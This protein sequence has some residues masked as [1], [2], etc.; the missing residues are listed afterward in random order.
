MSE[1]KTYFVLFILS[2]S[3]LIALGRILQ[4]QV[5]EREEFQKRIEKQYYQEEEIILPRGTIFDRNGKFAAI[6][7]PT[8]SVYVIPKY[9]KDKENTAKQLSLLLKIPYE[10]LRKVLYE[11]KNYTII[12]TNVDKSLRP[13]LEKLRFDLKEWNIGILDNSMRFYPFGFTA[14]NVIGFVSKKT[15]LGLEGMEYQ[16]NDY[17]GGGKA[18][19]RFLK[20]AKG[21]LIAIE[22]ADIQKKNYNAVLT[23]D[24]NVQHI[25]EDSLMELV[26]ER[27]P[28]EAAVLIMNPYTGEILAA[29]SYPNYDPNNYQAYKYR[30]NI[31]FQHAYEVGSV[32]KPIILAEAIDEKK[33]NLNEIIDC[34]NGSIYVDGIRI[35]DHKKFGLLTPVQIIQHSSNVGAIKIALRLDPKSVYKKLRDLGFGQKTGIFPG[36]ASGSLKEDYRPVNIAY[37]SIG[38]NWTATVLQVGVAYSAFA[39]GGYLVKPMLLKGLTDDSGNYVKVFQ[40]QVVKKVLSDESIEKI[41]PILKLVVEDGT[42]KSGKSDFFTIAGKTGTAQKYDPTIK[43]LSNTKWYTWFAGFFPVEK[44]MFTVV[45]FANE[46]KPKFTGE[47]IG[48]GGVSAT[49]LKNLV[50]RIMFY[51]KQKPDKVKNLDTPLSSGQR[52]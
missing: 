33:V 2:F 23:I 49:V 34:Q 11:R 8:L 32:A 47:H 21:N 19:L 36:E 46:P 35:R 3:F 26:Q 48:G 30:K 25:A 14:G 15:G 44:P 27:N 24:M 51:Y 45:V 50:D 9:I 37:A 18:K 20:D 22:K 4:I 41:K 43:A 38:Q 29:A 40:P 17:L 6:S 52:R 5:F 31:V 7:I 28:L 13:Q 39:N 10:D 1:K 16:L 42:A 12:A